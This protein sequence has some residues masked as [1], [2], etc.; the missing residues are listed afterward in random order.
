MTATD[1]NFDKLA[2][3]FGKNIYTTAK[4]RIRLAIL[5]RDLREVVADIDKG[6]LQILDVGAGQ[7]HFALQLAKRGHNLT[8]SDISAVMLDMAQAMFADALPQQQSYFVHA[9]IQTLSE[10]VTQHYDLVLCHA[11]LEWLADPEQAVKSLLPFVKP[12]GYL[13]LM[14]YSRTGLVYQNL[15]HGNFSH[16]FNNSLAGDGTTLTPVNP[17]QPEQV[18]AWLQQTGWQQKIKSGV[19]VFY[20]GIHRQRRKEISEEELI[21]LELRFSRMEPYCS[22]ARYVHV[23]YQRPL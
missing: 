5:M 20:D 17:Q 13:S 16:I 10:H 12:G 2:R 8:L 7:G 15:V 3:R 23:V 6:G 14:F 9:P 1:V 21:E 11:V 18:L 4:G 19:R 22:L